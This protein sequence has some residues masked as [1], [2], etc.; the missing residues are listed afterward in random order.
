MYIYI[1]I[2]APEEAL[3]ARDL[4]RAGRADVRP[5]ALPRQRPQEDRRAGYV[6]TIIMITT[7][8]VIITIVHTILLLLSLLLLLIYINI[9]IYIYTHTYIGG[10]RAGRQD[11]PGLVG[12]ECRPQSLRVFARSRKHGWSKHG[13]S[14]IPSTYSTPQDLY[15]PYLNLMN[16]A[17]TTFTPTM[18]SHRRPRECPGGGA[19]DAASALGS[20]RWLS[21]HFRATPHEGR[22][23]LSLRT[24]M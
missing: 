22:Q 9:Y 15:N 20:R 3:P 5:D 4:R 11:V 10:Q 24:G 17:R 18:F 12:C 1:Y 6:I 8:Y 21:S 2:G 16:H 7:I 13:S 14:M 19:L 23:G